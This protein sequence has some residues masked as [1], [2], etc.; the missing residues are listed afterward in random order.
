MSIEVRADMLR[1]DQLVDDVIAVLGDRRY[2]VDLHIKVEVVWDA[3]FQ[4]LCAVDYFLEAILHGG[5]G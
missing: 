5:E 2:R 4:H 3:W 1:Y